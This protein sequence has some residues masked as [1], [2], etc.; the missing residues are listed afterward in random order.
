MIGLSTRVLDIIQMQEQLIG[1][2]L[3][4]TAIFSSSVG[5]NTQKANHLLIK[6]WQYLVV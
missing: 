3:H 1:M 4:S 5:Q 6:K 2:F